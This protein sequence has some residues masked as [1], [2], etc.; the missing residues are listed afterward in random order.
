MNIDTIFVCPSDKQRKKKYQN[1]GENKYHIDM[2][3][4]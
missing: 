1:N 2:Y 4:T 3:I